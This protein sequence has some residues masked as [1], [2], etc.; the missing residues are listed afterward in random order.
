MLSQTSS[1][2]LGSSLAK[3]EILLNDPLIVVDENSESFFLFAAVLTIK[4][5]VSFDGSLHWG[6]CS[7]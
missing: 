6:G 1:L 4:S 7:E 2:Q 5:W 3:I